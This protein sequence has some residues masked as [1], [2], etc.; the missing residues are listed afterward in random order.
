[1][2]LR[3]LL[4]VWIALFSMIKISLPVIDNPLQSG[5]QCISGAIPQ[6]LLGL[7]KI[8]ETGDPAGLGKAWENI[9]H[10]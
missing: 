1:M 9:H 10:V 7:F 2:E 6:V 8:Q 4:K 3:Q 5:Q